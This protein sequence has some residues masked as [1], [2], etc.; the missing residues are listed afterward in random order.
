MFKILGIM[1][2]GL[3]S[4]YL[5]RRRKMRFMPVLINILIMVLLFIL[6]IETGSN[7]QIIENLDSLGGD[8]LLMAISMILFSSLGALLLEKRKKPQKDE[9]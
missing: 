9:K 8:A 6:G 7:K 3:V 1:C 5:L 4:G 2:L